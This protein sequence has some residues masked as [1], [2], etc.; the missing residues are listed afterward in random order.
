MRVET[1]V[2]YFLVHVTTQH[3]YDVGDRVF[4]DGE[5][6]I[7]YQIEFSRTL[8]DVCIRASRRRRPIGLPWACNHL[9]L[10]RASPILNG[11]DSGHLLS[12]LVSTG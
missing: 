5:N 11:P 2:A 12:C 4:I 7:V 6:L 8:F 3:P 9:I 10:L 1:H